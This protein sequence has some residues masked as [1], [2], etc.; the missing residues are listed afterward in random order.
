MSATSVPKCHF[1]NRKKKKQINNNIKN[2]NKNTHYIKK[3]FHFSGNYHQ[4]LGH[5][6]FGDH[7]EHSRTLQNRSNRLQWNQS[8]GFTSPTKGLIGNGNFFGSF[9]F[10]YFLTRKWCLFSFF[11]LLFLFSH[12]RWFK[13]RDGGGTMKVP[14]LE[15][16]FGFSFFL[17]GN[18]QWIPYSIWYILL[19]LDG[20]FT[21]TLMRFVVKVDRFQ[22]I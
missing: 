5:F 22:M 18:Y 16:F 3:R 14:F 21:Q 17:G 15:Q 20:S 8:V 13:L 6:S 1:Q 9:K 4:F 11:F 19:P 10:W 12:F 2:S 7:H